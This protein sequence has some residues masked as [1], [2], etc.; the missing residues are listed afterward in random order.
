MGYI[1]DVDDE[2]VWSPSLSTGRLYV[3]LTNCIAEIENCGTGLTAIADDMYEIDLPDFRVLVERVYKSYCS[4][5]HHIYR[6]Q[7]NGWILTSLVLLKRGGGSVEK[8]PGDADEPLWGQ[9]DTY[10]KAMPT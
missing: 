2:T 3:G 1:F 7:L 6:G 5:R 9:I 10:E 8:T 4:T